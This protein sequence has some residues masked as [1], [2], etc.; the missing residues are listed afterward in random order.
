MVL[1]VHFYWTCGKTEIKADICERE[2]A[3]G[4][5]VP[6]EVL[7]LIRSEVFCLQLFRK[8]LLLMLPYSKAELNHSPGKTAEKVL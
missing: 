5:L 7:S 3:S 2:D 8:A 1:G 6:V 4:N